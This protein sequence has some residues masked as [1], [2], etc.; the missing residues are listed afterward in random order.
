MNE[1]VK[2]L[3]KYLIDGWTKDAPIDDFKVCGA[4]QAKKKISGIYFY[5]LINGDNA[6]KFYVGKSK[7]LANRMN[8]YKRTF[9]CRSPDDSKI[10]MAKAALERWMECAFE[11]VLYFLPCGAA[12]LTKKE[13]DMI[14]KYQPL[15]NPKNKQYRDRAWEQ[16]VVSHIEAAYNR[17][18]D[19]FVKIALD[20]KSLDQ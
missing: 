8:D 9:Q 12:E 7:N 6:Y 20:V 11:L 13:T 14:K 5:V 3:K 15:I 19:E 18:F 1:N 2:Y 17:Y 16:T 4:D 10:R